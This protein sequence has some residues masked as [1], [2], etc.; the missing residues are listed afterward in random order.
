MHENPITGLRYTEPYFERTGGHAADGGTPSS[1]VDAVDPA[2]FSDPNLLFDTICEA[3]G[4]AMRQMRAEL[5]ESHSRVA[6][7]EGQIEMMTT[8]ITSGGAQWQRGAPGEPGPMGPT[9][10]PGERGER[11]PRGEPGRDGRDGRDAMFD[12]VEID[13]AR[14][15]LRLLKSDGTPLGPPI[16]IRDLFE[17]YLLETQGA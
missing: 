1:G 12:K 10:L 16:C 4:M 3:M 14:Y 9:G 11:G 13:R 15:A 2:L 5:A 8:L 6:K 17:Q 7:L